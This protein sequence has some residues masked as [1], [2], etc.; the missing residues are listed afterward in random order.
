MM[1]SAG[2]LDF[3]YEQFAVDPVLAMDEAGS[4][5]RW[6]ASACCNAGVVPDHVRDLAPGLLSDIRVVPGGAPLRA[7]SPGVGLVSF[8]NGPKPHELADLSEFIR[9]HWV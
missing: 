6:I 4:C 1:W 3:I 9:D 7:K 5:G 2:K 8:K